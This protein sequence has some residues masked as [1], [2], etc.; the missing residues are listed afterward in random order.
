MTALV[1]VLSPAHDIDSPSGRTS[2]LV[3]W[4]G[5]RAAARTFEFLTADIRNPN[6]RRAYHHAT[7]RFMRWCMGRNIALGQVT[8][9]IVAAY[10]DELKLVRR[11]S[12]NG[13][14]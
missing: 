11:C 6:T 7:G 4:G 2:A 10:V 9:P 3:A 14:P 1:P 13:R 8:S 5:D 12:D